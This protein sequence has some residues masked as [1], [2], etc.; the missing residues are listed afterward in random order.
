MNWLAGKNLP[1]LLFVVFSGALISAIISTVDS[2]LLAISALVSHNLLVP[3]FGLRSERARV[4]SARL[5]GLVSGVLA[6]A[7]ALYA[8]GNYELVLTASSFGTAGI[9][10]VT[11]MG[12]FSRAG[13]GAAAGSTPVTGLILTPLSTYIFKH[14]APP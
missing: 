10:V 3:L 2:I 7:I 12:L 14:K 11:L 6:Y 4:L 13:G 9:L 1:R 8:R 5:V